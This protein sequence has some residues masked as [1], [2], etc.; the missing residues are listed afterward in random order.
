MILLLYFEVKL[1]TPSQF[2]PGGAALYSLQRFTNIPL[3]VFEA[4]DLKGSNDSDAVKAST[5]LSHC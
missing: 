5:A 1:Y 2:L 3:G 4:K